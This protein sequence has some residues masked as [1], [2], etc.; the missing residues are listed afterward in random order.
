MLLITQGR[1]SGTLQ[2]YSL[3]GVVLEGKVVHS[4]KPHHVAFNCTST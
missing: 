3:P 2:Y 1:E 4:S